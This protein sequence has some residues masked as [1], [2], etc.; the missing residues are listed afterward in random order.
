VPGQL[1]PFTLRTFQTVSIA[2]CS[3]IGPMLL[4]TSGGDM[5]GVPKLT[6]LW[7][8]ADTGGVVQFH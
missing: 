3:D 2:L 6:T 7:L 8:K 4:P 1:G 5:S